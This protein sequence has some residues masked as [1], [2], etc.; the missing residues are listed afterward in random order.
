MCDTVSKPTYWCVSGDDPNY[1]DK[2]ARVKKVN[3][4]F[5][6]RFDK[7]QKLILQK[8]R[9]ISGRP[10]IFGWTNLLNILFKHFTFLKLVINPTLQVIESAYSNSSIVP[11]LVEV[12]D[13]TNTTAVPAWPNEALGAPCSGV[14]PATG[15]TDMG[16][17]IEGFIV[18]NLLANALGAKDKKR[19]K[20]AMAPFREAML[21]A[22][23]D[24]K[25]RGTAPH[26]AK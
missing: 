11:C 7:F 16:W 14:F 12:V 21:I 22:L 20:A 18:D 6:W 2:F 4:F 8:S 17:E 1:A 24:S 9:A 3:M 15:T 19:R 23:E 26:A 5:L 25:G 10:G 13:A